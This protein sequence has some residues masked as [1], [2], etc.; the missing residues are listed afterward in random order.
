LLI[1]S[2][3]LPPSFLKHAVPSFFIFG[4]A[5][6][7]G[8]GTQIVLLSAQTN[9]SAWNRRKKHRQPERSPLGLLPTVIRGREQSYQHCATHE[10]I[11]LANEHKW[12]LTMLTSARGVART[13]ARR[14]G[15]LARAREP[16]RKHF[17]FFERKR[18]KK[19]VSEPSDG[20]TALVKD[21]M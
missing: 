13:S 2:F 9:L 17:V 16:L 1:F 11:A 4:F 14:M 18:K 5:F 3:F 21:K 6:G 8:S 12:A 10:K 7:N 20:V 15:H 19:Y